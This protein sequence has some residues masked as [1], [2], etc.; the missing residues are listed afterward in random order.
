MTPRRHLPEHPDAPKY[1]RYE[2]GGKLAEAVHLYL[3]HPE[4]LGPT[5]I[6]LLRDYFRQWIDSP[7]WDLMPS[8]DATSVA[9]L[10]A[11]R[12]YAAHIT[13]LSEINLWLHLALN[14]GHDPL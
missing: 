6:G 1:W 9:K 14:E 12:V 13:S 5:A 4:S 11:L 7:V 8:H 3:T 2:T 10:K